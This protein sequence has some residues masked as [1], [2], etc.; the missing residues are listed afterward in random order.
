MYLGAV[1]ALFVGVLA[2][3]VKQGKRGAASEAPG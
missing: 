1:A 2:L 3:I